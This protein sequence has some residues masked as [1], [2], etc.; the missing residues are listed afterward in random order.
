MSSVSYNL[1]SG[2]ICQNS[3]VCVKV[4]SNPC[5]ALRYCR[6]TIIIIITSAINDKHCYYVKCTH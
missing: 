3:I 2:E 4:L 1:V 6:A 5:V